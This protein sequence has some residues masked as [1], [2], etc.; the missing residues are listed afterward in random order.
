M[1]T[2]PLKKPPAPAGRIFPAPATARRRR[3]EAFTGFPGPPRKKK[4][5][6]SL[7]LERLS[8]FIDC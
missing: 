6:E 8:D 4:K 7:F 5:P 2:M 1:A 3:A